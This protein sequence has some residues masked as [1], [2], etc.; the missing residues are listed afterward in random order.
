MTRFHKFRAEWALEL[1]LVGLM[2]GFRAALLT[3]AA[4]PLH[5]DEAVVLLMARHIL[6]GARPVFFYGQA[7]MGSLDAYLVAGAFALFGEGLAVARAVQL[8]LY[9]ALLLLTAWGLRRLWAPRPAR[10]ALLYLAVPPVLLTIYSTV[11]LGGYNEALLLGTAGLVGLGVM[12]LGDDSAQAGRR[13]LL[14]GLLAG[15]GAWVLA[16]SWVYLLPAGLAALRHW[17]R[18]GRAVALSGLLATALGAGLGLAPVWIFVARH[19][20]APLLAESP[21]R[22]FPHFAHPWWRGIPWHGVMLVFAGWP[23]VAG[24]R[25][26]WEWT[27]R[28]A[29][30][31]VGLVLALHAA[32]WAAWV[33][34]RARVPARVWWGVTGVVLTNALLFV[35]TPYGGD[36]TGRYFLPWA[37]AQAV[38]LAGG[39]TL[40]GRG[41][42]R[43][44]A[45]LGLAALV[46]VHAGV[47]G[48]AARAP[49]GL[50]PVFAAELR[51]DLADQERLRDFLLAHDLPTGYTTYWVAY[52]LAFLSHERLQYSPRLPY[53][54][55]LRYTPRDDRIPAYTR[56][57]ACAPRVAYVT[58]VAQAEL[59]RR[60]RSG[61]DRAGVTWREAEVGAYRVF[62]DLSRPIAPWDLGLSPPSEGVTCGQ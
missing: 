28:A 3:Q 19:G 1:A 10:L 20:W 62:Y 11:T 23:V 60:L 48:R 59:N 52:P 49:G 42:A 15:L 17:W 27:P 37:H 30:P 44:A 47:T 53:H 58:F 25:V 54:R 32:A 39:L 21:T 5:A 24:L 61:L 9:A 22:A 2:L 57:A 16:L 6:R 45:V 50:S 26:P 43:R 35:F 18:R 41:R 14:L 36:P 46:L 31:V 40:L 7:Y 34:M 51:A 13:G 38:V 29:W 4:F 55:D 33:R 56:T 12:G 8:G